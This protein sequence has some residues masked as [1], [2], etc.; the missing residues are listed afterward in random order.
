MAMQRSIFRKV[1]LDRLSS[2]EQLD[3]LLRVTDRRGWLALTAIGML[4]ATAVLWGILGT[5]SSKISGEGLLMRHGGLRTVVSSYLGEVTDFHVA[6]GDVIDQG[7]VVASLFQSSPGALNQ[8]RY[9]ASPY[10]GRVL[11]IMTDVGSFVREGTRLLNLEPLDEP[12]EV[13]VYVSSSDGKRVQP[14]M[15]VEISPATVRPEEYGYLRGRVRSASAFPVTREGMA[16]VMGTAD[17]ATQF[18]A[19]GQPYEI[20]V[21][22]ERDPESFSGFR[23][24]SRGPDVTIEAGT[25]CSAKIVIEQQRPIEL[26]IPRIK[27]TLGLY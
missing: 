19:A 13:V 24:S 1:A 22:L 27:K 3:Q 15:Q 16:R 20:V 5:A 11:E 12:L 25:M 2:P 10:S 17:L 21:D 9:V 23:W 26:V 4:L 14:G 6:V 7:Q 8:L 18:S